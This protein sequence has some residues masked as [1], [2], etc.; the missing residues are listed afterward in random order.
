[1]KKVV[2]F[3]AGLVASAHVKYLLEHSYQV[4]VAT[5]TV[6]KAKKIVGRHP[7]G[8]AVAFDIESEGDT[9]LD[10]IVRQHDLA[11]SLLALERLPHPRGQ[12]VPAQPQAHGDHLVRQARDAG[13]R[14][15]GE[16]ARP[17]PAQRTGQGPRHRPHDGDEG[18][19]PRPARGR[20]DHELHVVLRRPAGA[21]G[22][23]QPVR[24]QVPVEPARRADGRDATPPASAATAT[25]SRSPGRSCSSTTGASRSRSRAR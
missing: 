2:V 10:E 25:S 14:R 21:R 12:V 22:E 19:P 18:D 1:M 6:A 24:V 23:R 4:T 8:K 20:Q 17:R 3:G 13:A 16:E 11:V 7:N 9:R 5:R 15:R